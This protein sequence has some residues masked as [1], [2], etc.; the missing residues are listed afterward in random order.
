MRG[1]AFARFETRFQAAWVV[2]ALLGIIPVAVA[3]GQGGLALVLAFGG[4]S[5]LAALRAARSRPPRSK[6]RPEAVDRVVGRAR[7]NL[8]ERARQ[9]RR[10]RRRAATAERRTRRSD[11]HR[12]PDP[13]PA[14]ERASPPAAKPPAPRRSTPAAAS[15]K[16]PPPP[17][18]RKSGRGNR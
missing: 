12:A 2:G 18:R 6:L 10:G 16:V 1:R 11:E 8:R 15:N 13:K 9:S 7:D 5:Y 4:L 3:A 14:G 17:R